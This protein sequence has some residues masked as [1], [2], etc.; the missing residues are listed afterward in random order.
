MATN[1]K[2]GG[3]YDNPATGKNQR[4]WNGVWTDGEDPTQ[5]QAPAVAPTTA[6]QTPA[7]S[8][9][10]AN[11]ATQGT[12]ATAGSEQALIA[13]M[14]Q[15]GHT[16]ES[17][18]AAIAGRGVAD[19]SR[20]YL[21][22]GSSTSATG[23]MPNQP[24]I[25]L[26][27]I[28]R[29]LTQGS[30]V[31]EKEADLSKKTQE[32]AEA[33]AK[34]NDNPFLSEATRVGRV[35]K[36]DS[37]FN[38]QVA[39]IQNEI[40]MKK[41]DIETQ[42]NLQT[43]QFDIQSQQAQQAISQFNSLLASGALDNASGS[44]I[45]SITAS[46]GISSDMIASAVNNR[47]L[48]SLSTT[49]QTFDDGTNEGF[50]IYTIDPSGQIVNE[51]IKVTGKS[52]KSA[53]QYSADSWVSSFLSQYVNNQSPTTSNK[54]GVAAAAGAMIGGQGLDDISTLW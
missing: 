18:K 29:S 2:L 12:S 1:Y 21:Q 36:L 10:A 33:K 28:Y 15:K 50:I 52:S 5:G 16:P 39:G 3:W 54:T 19:L 4:W 23:M 24:T 47:R 48:S 26:P 31:S 45:A 43:K 22:T 6:P 37:L 46:T 40:A 27:G 30:G 11:V 35:A 34:I 38:D 25:D 9:S 17:A 53:V 49:T 20:E 42:L 44:D 13:A 7:N 8:F 32:L 14:T 41:A 51:E